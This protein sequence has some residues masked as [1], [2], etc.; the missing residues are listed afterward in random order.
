MLMNIE[1]IKSDLKE[2]MKA[3]DSLKSS[4]LRSIMSAYTNELIAKG[5][6][7]TDTL[8]D[9][10]F[11]SLLKRLLKQRKESAEQFRAG[12]REDLAEKE[13]KEAEIISNYLPEQ[14]SKEEIEKVAKEIIDEMPDAQTGQII[15]TV[16]KKFNGLADGSLVKEVIEKLKFQ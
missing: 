14:P 7:P 3:K 16:I 11:V 1:T 2:A 12:G 9:K 8:D 4:V 15:G 10:E 13:E 6:K 5:R